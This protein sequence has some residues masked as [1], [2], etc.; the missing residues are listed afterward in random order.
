MAN[1][2]TWDQFVVRIAVNAGKDALYHAWATRNGIEHW[3]LRVS[4]YRTA[5]GDARNS[6]EPVQAGDTYSWRWHGWPDEVEEHGKILAANG[7]DHFRFTFGEAGICDVR[8][9]DENGY[10]VVEL[11]QT[12]IPEDE[13]GKQYW[14]IGCRTGW[15]FYLTNMKSLFEGGIDLRNRDV[16]LKNVV[17]S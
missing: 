11:V 7:K 14:H 1:Q 16:E 2:N 6:D 12:E 17:N 15:T 5:N 4:D 3:F 9:R 13:H 10:Q 8:I